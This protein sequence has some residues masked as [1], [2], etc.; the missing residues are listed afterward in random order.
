MVQEKLVQR[1][2]KIHMRILSAMQ[3]C[4]YC[5]LLRGIAYSLCVSAER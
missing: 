2:G 5:Y 3:F 4:H 1:I